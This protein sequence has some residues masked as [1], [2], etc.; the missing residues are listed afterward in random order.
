MRMTVRSAARA[1]LIVAGT[2]PSANERARIAPGVTLEGTIRFSPDHVLMP[3]REMSDGHCAA[4]AIR[5]SA[6]QRRTT[7]VISATLR[8]NN[9]RKVPNPMLILWFFRL[10]RWLWKDH[11]VFLRMAEWL[12]PKMIRWLDNNRK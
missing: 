2:S 8:R 3:S 11:K 4:S 9:A 10:T 1:R 6:W 7:W 12:S 5:R